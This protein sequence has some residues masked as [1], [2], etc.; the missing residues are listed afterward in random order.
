[1]SN[2]FYLRD[3]TH[4]N[5]KNEDVVHKDVLFFK[6]DKAGFDGKATKEHVK[7][8]PALFE[9]FS[10]AHPDYKLPEHFSKVEVGSPVTVLG[11]GFGHP[12]AVEAE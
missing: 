11:E 7:S 9:A 5:V 4:K 3:E 6:H 8:Y 2:G 1:M 12:V 10:S